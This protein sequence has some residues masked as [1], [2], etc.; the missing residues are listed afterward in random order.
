M[1]PADDAAFAARITAGA[2]AQMAEQT[3]EISFQFSYG[4]KGKN[5]REM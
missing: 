3:P 2:F 1:H 4:L 5:L